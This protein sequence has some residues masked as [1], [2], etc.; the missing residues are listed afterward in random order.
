MHFICIDWTVI[1]VV[2]TGTFWAA[3]GVASAGTIEWDYCNRMLVLCT[4]FG[5]V[6][7]KTL[8]VYP[9]DKPFS[10]RQVLSR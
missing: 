6:V 2:V 8:R 1:A 7:A 9:L 4:L 10:E 3:S 5:C